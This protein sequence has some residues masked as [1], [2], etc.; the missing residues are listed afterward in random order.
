M[1]NN[2]QNMLHLDKSVIYLFLAAFLVSA[3]VLA[4]KYIKFSPCEEVSFDIKAQ[5]YTIGELIK[6]NDG[7]IGATN[8]R[9]D[10][11]DKTPLFTQKEALHIYKQP[12]E[13]VV[14]LIVNNTCESTKTITIK[15]KEV[16][17]DSTK[18]PVFEIP[19]S[20]M[21]GKTL[22][23][24]DK[25]PNATTWEWRFGETAGSNA[26]TRKAKYVFIEP[27][28][29]TVSLIVNGDLK[30]ITKKRIEVI[31]TPESKKVVVEPIAQK[32]PKGWNIK[33]KPENDVK[34]KKSSPKVVPYISD[35]EFANKII[36]VSQ[37]KMSPKQ[38]SEYFCG[39]V[40]KPVIVNGKNTTFL[41]FCEKIKDKK[42]KLKKV[43]LFRDKGSN[44]IKTV[45]L[46]YKKP[47]LF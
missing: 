18:F 8:W 3:T 17:I 35:K 20:I 47:G 42:I 28:L 13:Y 19:K 37:E 38:F 29:K 15:D 5:K 25:T 1:S 24:E 32:K 31:P 4:Y 2:N 45:T 40:N 39:D 36:L 30:Y 26:N 11:G 33:L 6:F 46:D 34:N 14:T 21:F 12:G 44:C 22:S 10:F 16:V 41:V 43:E 23:V 9:W 27:G 7:T